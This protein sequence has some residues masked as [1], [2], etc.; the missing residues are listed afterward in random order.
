MTI[1][2]RYLALALAA[3]L[4]AGYYLAND[5][6]RPPSP[7]DRPILA[8]IA[9]LAKTG[10]WFLLIAEPPPEPAPAGELVH[11]VVGP[12]GHPAINHRE[13]W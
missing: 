10:L 5:R 7:A 1:P 11:H 6:P 4:A 13:G 9:R 3:A 2:K 12:D 8:A